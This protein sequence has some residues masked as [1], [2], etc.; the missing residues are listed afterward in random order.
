[1]FYQ[2]VALVIHLQAVLNHNCSMCHIE[3]CQRRATPFDSLAFRRKV[4]RTMVEIAISRA[5]G[6]DGDK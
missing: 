2:Q 1:M 4:L 3:S 5:I 6:Y